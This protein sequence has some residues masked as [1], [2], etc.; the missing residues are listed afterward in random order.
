M[1]IVNSD[2]APAA[3]GPYS[4][5]VKHENFVFCSGQ[6]PLNV[7]GNIVSESVTE[8]THQ[9]FA[10]LKAVLEAAGSS[11][12]KVVKVTM[13]LTDLNDFATVNEI[14]ASYFIGEIKPARSTIQVAA[15]PRGAKVEVECIAIL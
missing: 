8:Q 6:I 1:E 13:F 9:V 12:D 3:I 2:Q 7:E 14:Y 11:F 10:N 4:Q 15:L 5:A